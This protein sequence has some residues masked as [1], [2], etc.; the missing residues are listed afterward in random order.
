MSQSFPGYLGQVFVQAEFV[1][2]FRLNEKKTTH[3][4]QNC[5]K[6]AFYLSIF[7]TDH[8][9]SHSFNAPNA[10]GPHKFF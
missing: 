1:L 4:V 5:V 7:V 9:P 10:A 2:K 8:S 6:L 3:F